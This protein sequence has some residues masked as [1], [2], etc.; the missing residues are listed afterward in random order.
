MFKMKFASAFGNCQG[1]CLGKSVF[2]LIC[3]N[4]LLLRQNCLNNIYVKI[5]KLLQKVKKSSFSDNF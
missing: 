5:K 2:S 4:K 3:A 1:F